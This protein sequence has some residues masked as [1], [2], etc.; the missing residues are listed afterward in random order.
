MAVPCHLCGQPVS[1]PGIEEGSDSGHLHFCCLGCRQV[2]QLLCASTGTL[3]EGFRQT[4]LFRACVEW[5]IIPGPE[6]G[7]SAGSPVDVPAAEPLDLTFRVVG[8]WCPSC[9]WLIREVL[10]RSPGVTHADVSFATDT[11]RLKYLPH[12]ISPETIVARAQRLGYSFVATE[13]QEAVRQSWARSFSGSVSPP[14]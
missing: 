11:V 7:P 13:R 5:G 4:E 2:F 1:T 10:A 3:P 8:M 6:G 12:K 9:A 14:Y